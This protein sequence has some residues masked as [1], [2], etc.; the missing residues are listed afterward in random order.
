MN[1]DG[2]IDLYLSP[3][4]VKGYEANT[5]IMNPE[6]PA[7]LCFRFYGAKPELWEKNSRVRQL[8]GQFPRFGEGQVCRFNTL[9]VEAAEVV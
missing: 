6:E 9:R 7:F 4:P 1:E 2:S 5:V 8:S 3:N